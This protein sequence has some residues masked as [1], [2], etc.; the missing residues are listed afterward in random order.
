MGIAEGNSSVPVYNRLSDG[1]LLALTLYPES[2]TENARE[3]LAAELERRGI[4]KEEVAAYRS[5][6][7][8]NRARQERWRRVRILRLKSGVSSCLIWPLI[9][10]AVC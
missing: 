7:A 9:L 8:K 2:L 6:A 3:A 5:D 1:E 10:L 4:S